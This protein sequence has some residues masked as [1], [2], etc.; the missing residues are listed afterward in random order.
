MPRINNEYISKFY[1]KILH[2]K[3]CKFIIF[4]LILILILII[5]YRIQINNN[6]NIL[7][8]DRYDSVISASILE[9]WHNT[10][11]KGTKW[12]EMN[13]FYPYTKTIAQTD[14]YL[15]L[16]ILYS[17]IRMLGFDQFLSQELTGMLM[18]GLGFFGMFLFFAKIFKTSFLWSIL[19]A[20]LFTLSN[21]N[22]VHLSRIQISVIAIIPY[23]IL[24]IWISIENLINLNLK[25]SIVY[26]SISGILYGLL[27][28]SCFYIAWYF[29]FFTFIFTITITILNFKF[30]SIFIKNNYKQFIQYLSIVSLAY[31]LGILPF[32]YTFYEKSK[33]VGVRTYESVL[34]HTIPLENI[35]QVGNENIF[36]GKLYNYFLSY[37]SKGYI[38][39]GE[40]YNCGF[41][42]I[43]FIVFIFATFYY[44]K[45]Y[46]Y[47]KNKKHTVLLAFSIT[48]IAVVLFLL[49]FNTFSLWK[50]VY[51][52]FPGAKALNAVETFMIF[53]VIP[54]ILVSIKY[55]STLRWTSVGIF[56]VVFTLILSEINTPHLNL[57]RHE[58]LNILDI[59]APPSV[60]KVF[61]VT[62]LENQDI[63]EN[64]PSWINNY[65]AHNV[66]AIYI[67]Q[68]FN[69]PT[70][71]GVA[72]F[73]HP[74]WNFGYPNNHDYDERV[75]KYLKNHNIQDIC[76]LNLN[77]KIWEFKIIN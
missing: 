35:L 74:D 29:V 67:A 64:F 47:S 17:P 55:L 14:A 53:L 69:M 18:R 36:L 9:H 1:T 24:F 33:E 43:L 49:K 28:M 59:K 70:I 38:P 31:M 46:R 6:F 23:M 16:G 61:Y 57:K 62:G 21:S 72:S 76:K 27:A 34:N 32:I 10:F 4:L 40:Y 30:I 20:V 42:F 22:T 15:L 37:V 25:K 52:Y 66:L 65:Y 58:Q 5:I 12:S 45:N 51:N 11:T 68:K 73:N 44:F 39:N 77:N 19:A 48:T 41:P 71:N 75:I 26:G 63:I 7:S 50:Y 3:L 54:I 2:S 56:I 8:G 60:C 13:Y